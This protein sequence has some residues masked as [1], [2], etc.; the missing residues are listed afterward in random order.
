MPWPI[1]VF[2]KIDYPK[3]ISWRMWLPTLAALASSAV[4][5]VL[6]LWPHGKPTNT[7]QFWGTL[8][9]APLVACALVFGLKLDHWEGEQ[10]DAEE[11][12][13][14]QLRLTEM[15]RDWARRH[16]SI[17][18]VAAFPAAT[19]E[20]ARFGGEKIELPTKRDRAIPFDW[21]D[22]KGA[23][24]RRAHLLQLIAG[25]FADAL[26]GQSEIIVTLMLDDGSL[27]E[28]EA[29]TQQ[30]MSVFGSIVPD[31]QFHIEAQPATGGVD[32]I[33]RQVDQIDT[34]T[35]L[36]IAAQLWP[37]EDGAR[38]FSEGAAA[39]LIEPG[40]TK[41]GSIFRPMTGTRDTLESGLAQIGQIQTSPD[42]LRQVWV[43]GCQDDESTAIRSALTR[44]P[45]DMAVERLLDG[46]LGKPGPASGWIAMAIAM[47]AMRGAGPQLVAWREPESESLHLCTV[48][49]LPHEETTV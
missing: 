43:T 11:A 16:L 7:F 24:L 20:V 15:W 2:T 48:S 25:R 36:V 35:R 9:G 46:V 1:P 37:E 18:G 3:P 42:R 5:A 14:E 4:A 31:A 12:D 17:V 6:L 33:T 41:S 27:R 40:A 49:P 44:D 13:K 47:E 26:R 39:F 23:T 34:A 22:A 45:K 10:T 38:G 29:W 19:E 8:V 30:A 28:G 21:V 32:W